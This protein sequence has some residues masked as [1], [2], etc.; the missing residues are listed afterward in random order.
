[1]YSLNLAPNVSEKML[2]ADFWTADL[3]QKTILT[4]SEI[5]EFNQEIAER[6][7]SNRE[8]AYYADLNSLAAEIKQADLEFKIRNAYRKKIDRKK[9]YYN[10]KGELITEA[11]KKS[12]LANCNFEDI[13][14]KNQTKTGILIKR[15]NIR[16]LPTETVFAAQ[17]ESGD[18]D[19]MQLTALACGT[20]VVIDH[21]SKDNKYY[22]IESKLVSGWVKKA[23]VA[24]TDDL[25]SAQSYLNSDSFL[26]VSGS[27]V[28]TEPDPFKPKVS[29]RLFQMGDKIPLVEDY[30]SAND[31]SNQ[32]PHAQSALGN[33]LVWIPTKDENGRLKLE[34]AI[35][36][37]S[38]DIEEG[39]LDFTRENIIKQAFKMLGERYDW[40]GRYQ[41]RDCSRFIMDILR[42]FGFEAPRNADL[43]ELFFTDNK[44]IFGGDLKERK[45]KLKNLNP[46]D[47]LHMKGHIMLYLG[48][49]MDKDYLIH[50]ASG[51]SELDQDG[52]LAAKMVRS[53][54][55]MDVEQQLKD[56]KKSYLEKLVS[57]SKMG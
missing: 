22:F 16:G 28:E 50:A 1:M 57:A 26:V 43:Q 2:E 40:G 30:N 18:Q 35:I 6:A 19:L 51:Y 27:R 25:E 14:E 49:F 8:L 56:S 15:S 45:N 21:Q 20:A 38:S 39:H 34:K 52:N 46:G 36:A 5:E 23:N 31:L 37:Y 42:S 29:N 9:E 17:K 10:L 33:Y 13:K 41:R 53:V 48:E 3:D 4:D 47:L 55:L 24:L 12:F 11:E 7:R 44:Y 32:H 54:F